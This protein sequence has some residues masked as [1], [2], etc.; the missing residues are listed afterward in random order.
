MTVLQLIFS[1]SADVPIDLSI[2]DTLNVTRLNFRIALDK[3]FHS[4]PPQGKLYILNTE[5]TI[6]PNAI[7]A[8]WNFFITSAKAIPSIIEYLNMQKHL[9]NICIVTH[10]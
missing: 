5:D 9:L 2:H 6:I 7:N 8:I 10:F 4:S 1:I 3:A